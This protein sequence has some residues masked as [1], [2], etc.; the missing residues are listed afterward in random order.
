MELGELAE[1]YF[2]R[3]NKLPPGADG[4]DG[5]LV[6]VFIAMYAYTYEDSLKLSIATH[7][8]KYEKLSFIVTAVSTDKY[9]DTLNTILGHFNDKWDWFLTYL[10][11]KITKWEE[12]HEQLVRG[13][14]WSNLYYSVDLFSKE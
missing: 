5:E 8:Q 10:D 2:K 13:G 12:K 6:D 9:R 14:F 3:F 1:E 7:N 4:V 11:K